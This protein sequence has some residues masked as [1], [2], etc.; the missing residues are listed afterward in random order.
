LKTIIKELCIFWSAFVFLSLTTLIPFNAFAL[1]LTKATFPL[2]YE[3]HT[4][5]SAGLYLDKTTGDIRATTFLV[6]KADKWQVKV[7]KVT[8]EN[9]LKRVPIS[10][11]IQ[12]RARNAENNGIYFNSRK[13][14][15]FLQPE[16]CLTDTFTDGTRS[17]DSS[18]H[19]RLSVKRGDAEIA[20]GIEDSFIF[21]SDRLRGI[22]T[23][24]SLLA[25]N[26]GYNK[27]ASMETIQCTRL[28][29]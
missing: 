15:T 28:D 24:S 3:C 19:C 14:R 1:D 9:D 4:E 20:C 27:S 26:M 23:A 11:V 16:F 5:E 7:E 2:Y 17:I 8:S 13:D 21:D 18:S 10:C 25:L 6:N 12:R 22:R 29:R